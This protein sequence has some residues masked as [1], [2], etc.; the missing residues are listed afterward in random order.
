MLDA[1]TSEFGSRTKRENKFVSSLLY[2]LHQIP[3]RVLEISCSVSRSA[4]PIYLS[5]GHVAYHVSATIGQGIAP[6]RLCSG[7][8]LAWRFVKHRGRRSRND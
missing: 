6:I 2:R 3:Q 8:V 5:A 4:S 7:L 1:E